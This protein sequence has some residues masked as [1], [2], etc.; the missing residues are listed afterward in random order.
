MNGH[1]AAVLFFPLW[2]IAGGASWHKMKKVFF[3]QYL[4]PVDICDVCHGCQECD[5][6]PVCFALC[7]W[8]CCGLQEYEKRLSEQASMQTSFY[9]SHQECS[10]TE[11]YIRLQ[12]HTDKDTNWSPWAPEDDHAKRKMRQQCVFFSMQELG[13]LA[14]ETAGPGADSRDILVFWYSMRRSFH[15]WV[16][17]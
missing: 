2:S 12:G 13:P 17:V 10:V 8:A 16:W 4:L 1:A 15:C 11:C 14:M 7:A 3:H 9:M 6:I 5:G